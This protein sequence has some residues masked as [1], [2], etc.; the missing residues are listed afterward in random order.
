MTHASAPDQQ[1]IPVEVDDLVVLILGAP[2]DSPATRNRIEGITRLEKLVFLAER[3]TSA[4]EIL[5]EDPA[6]LAHKFGPFSSK[7]Y[8]AIDS[9]SAAGLVID[10]ASADD[11]TAD[12]WESKEVIDG[13]LEDPYVTR[14]LRLTAVGE[15]YYSALLSELPSNVEEEIAVFK[16]RYASLPLRRLIRYVYQRYP[17]FTKRSVIRD[18]ILG[19]T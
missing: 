11:S 12:T 19:K 14:D 2:S 4:A 17:D 7:V 18:D 3:E 15:Q 6:F 5:T 8:Q 9:L 13:G 10:S 1:Q 16:K